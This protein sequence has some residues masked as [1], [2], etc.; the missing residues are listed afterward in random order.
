MDIKRNHPLNRLLR[1][2][3]LF[4]DIIVFRNL[5]VKWRLLLFYLGTLLWFFILAAIGMFN[6]AS[7]NYNSS[8]IEKISRQDKVS[9][10]ITRK[11]RGVNISA[12]DIAL[13]KDHYIVQ[14][15]IEKGRNRLEEV[16]EFLNALSE[17]GYVR[18]SSNDVRFVF[19]QINVTG[20]SEDRKSFIAEAKKKAKSIGEQFEN[21]ITLK[22]KAPKDEADID[23]ILKR[24]QDIDKEI[25]DMIV[26]FGEFSLVNSKQMQLKKDDF[27]FRIVKYSVTAMT[28]SLF[29]ACLLLSLYLLRLYRSIMEPIKMIISYIRQISAG[30]ITIAGEL[31]HVGEKGEIGELFRQFKSFTEWF[32]N[33][34]SFKQIIEEDTKVEDVF[35]RLAAVLEQKISIN[36]FTIYTVRE[37]TLMS[38]THRIPQDTPILCNKEILTNRQQCRALQTGHHISSAEY[39]DICRLFLCPAEKGYYCV[40]LF[41][42]GH[43]V[44]VVQL[45]FDKADEND[46]NSI[47]TKISTALHYI[48]ASLSAIG[49]KKLQNELKELSTTDALTGLKNRRHLEQ[50]VEIIVSGVLRRKTTLAIFMCD[51]D[52][53]KS[54]NDTYGHDAGDTV[55]K[56]IAEV[57]RGSIRDS[58]IR[59]RYGG[60]EFIMILPDVENG[61]SIEKMAEG[62]RKKVENTQIS[63][64]ST[65]LKKTI[66]MGISEFPTDSDNF[67]EAVKFA[68]TALYQAKQTGRNKS[69]KYTADMAKDA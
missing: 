43:S 54:V 38:A 27:T 20:V 45:I 40:P 11:I 48:D 59:V 55:L 41:I 68:D 15:Q 9:Q 50:Y 4:V 35:F 39:A 46:M 60:E 64:G 25:T 23:M 61:G 67:F 14:Q 26:I 29:M 19:D 62:I 1:L 57:L 2:I 36:N 63:I 31:L 28:V 13:F 58:D 3:N 44:A 24:I 7:F 66:S 49:A 16:N 22:S 21:L 30:G 33:I 53:F 8:A 51:I 42:H 18:D 32:I 37:K 5:E 69:V 17:G 52:F 47:T 6:L 34:N 56:T 65:T 10:I 12:H